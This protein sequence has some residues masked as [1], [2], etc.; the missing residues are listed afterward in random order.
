MLKWGIIGCGDVVARKSGP[1]IRA[2]GG[3]RI[4]AV[5]RRDGTK[6]RA[7]AEANEIPL[8]TDDASIVLNHPEV[9]IV[10]VATPPYAHAEYVVGAAEAGKHVLVEKPMGMSADQARR[11]IAACQQAGREL[12]VAY[13]RRF[14]EHVMKM[15]ELV[16]GGAVGTPVQAFIDLAKPVRRG[17]AG[18]WRERVAIS[19]GGHFVDVGSHRLDL[20]VYLFGAVKSAC[21]VAGGYAK[22]GSAERVVS[23]CAEFECGV[24]LAA[25]GDYVSGRRADLLRVIGTGGEVRMDSVDSYAVTAVGEG[26]EKRFEFEKR[27]DHHVGLIHHIEAVLERGAENGCSGREGLQTEIILDEAVRKRRPWKN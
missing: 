13:Y 12:F 22:A 26:G 10:Y 8:A 20:M 21:G 6:A 7:Y 18:D 17:V 24:Q 9:D 14:Q 3:S 19:G 16:R 2:T 23:L 27:D 1:A 15:R 11:M 5:M 4:T 25:T